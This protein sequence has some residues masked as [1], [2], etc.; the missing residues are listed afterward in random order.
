[1]SRAGGRGA[2]TAA[3]SPA[4]YVAASD[5]PSTV[6]VGHDPKSHPRPEFLQRARQIVADPKYDDPMFHAL[7]MDGSMDFEMIDFVL[8]GGIPHSPRME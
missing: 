7:V 5:K 2:I 1:M 4:R 3:L 6:K 8:A